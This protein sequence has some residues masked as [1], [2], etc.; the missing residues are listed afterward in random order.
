MVRGWPRI[1]VQTRCSARQRV[2]NSTKQIEAS[3]NQADNRGRTDEQ[4][5]TG[6]VRD[7][8]STQRGAARDRRFQELAG[9]IASISSA[10]AAGCDRSQHLRL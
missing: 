4:S 3:K 1:T 2:S 10:A 9:L 5:T 6:V 7:Y 8:A